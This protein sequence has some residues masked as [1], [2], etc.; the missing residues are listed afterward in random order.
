MH[1]YQRFRTVDVQGNVTR[2]VSYDI[3]HRT[4][5]VTYQW[6]AGEDAHGYPVDYPGYVV[7]E[8]NVGWFMTLWV[9][10]ETLVPGWS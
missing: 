1:R 3:T 4:L 8:Y 9:R 10:D 7:S 5:I 6:Q 2:L